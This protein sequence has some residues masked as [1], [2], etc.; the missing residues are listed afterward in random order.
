MYVRRRL[1]LLFLLGVCGLPVLS[2]CD[3]GAPRRTG[4]LGPGATPPPLVAQAW[5]NGPAPS[6]SD[7]EGRVVVIDVWAHWCGPCMQ[8]APHIVAAYDRFKS[9][10]VVFVGLSPDD[11]RQESEE[12]LAT[13]RIPWT[14]GIGAGATCEALGV[15]TIP[16][17][18]VI[19]A[20]GRITWNSN[21]D[22]TLDEAIEAALERAKS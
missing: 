10:G 12:F 2:A 17:L 20:D 3:S 9:Q 18:F 4:M 13:A 6:A 15:R 1:A 21:L 7:L 5:L 16:T 22:G 19:G 14:N 11:A 8:A